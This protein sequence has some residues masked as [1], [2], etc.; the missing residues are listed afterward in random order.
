MPGIERHGRPAPGASQ[1][2]K[3]QLQKN[4]RRMGVGM[5]MTIAGLRL[6]IYSPISDPTGKPNLGSNRTR[7][8]AFR[9]GWSTGPRSPAGRPAGRRAFSR[10]DGLRPTH[11]L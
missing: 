6:A 1:G 8:P 10:P 3:S 9:S 5:D 4:E 2:I 11:N 7:N